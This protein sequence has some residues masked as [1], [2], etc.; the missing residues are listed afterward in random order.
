VDHRAG[1]VRASVVGGLL[2]GLAGAG[3]MSLAHALVA[4]RR[5]PPAAAREEDATVK[6][7]DALARAVRGR[8]L[9]RAEKPAAAT[10]VHYA[11][12]AVMGVLYGAAAGTAPVLARWG[13]LGFGAA[14]WLGA[15][16]VVVPTLGLARSPLRQPARQ[17][18]LELG[19]HLL[20]GVTTD[21][22]RRL[23][24]AIVA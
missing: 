21:V 16:A 23:A 20:Y 15:H 9:A 14:V 5:P 10:A 17:E 1:D 18:A 11:F 2:G 4:A 22:I 24:V 19:L 8:S 7:A 13:G 3:V 6:V 12:G